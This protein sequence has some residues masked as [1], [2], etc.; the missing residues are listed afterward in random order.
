MQ[1]TG[2]EIVQE[3]I[4]KGYVP[5]AIQQQG[6]DLR[7]MEVREFGH[8]N[9]QTKEW[10]QNFHLDC[11]GIIPTEGKTTLPKSELLKRVHTPVCLAGNSSRD[12]MRLSLK[13]DVICLK[14]ESWCLSPVQVVSVVVLKSSAVNLTPDLRQ[15]TWVALC[16]STNMYLS[17]ITPALHK[18]ASP[19]PLRLMMIRCTTANGK[20]TNNALNKS[21]H[22]VTC[23]GYAEIC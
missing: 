17:E 10:E 13:K 7:L 2:K 1:L 20:V 18:P 8:V 21:K 4:I 3:N 11:I 15:T 16:A 5:E 23:I 12:T 6:I 19:R 9:E 14:T 22:H